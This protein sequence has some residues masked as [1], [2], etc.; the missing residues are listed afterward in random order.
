DVGQKFENLVETLESGKA[1]LVFELT[2]GKSLSGPDASTSEDMLVEEGVIEHGADYALPCGKHSDT[3]VN[4]GR[5][6]H[7]EGAL[8]RVAAALRALFADLS[9]DTIVTNG[10]AMATLARRLASLCQ[11][12]DLRPVREIMCEG[13]D[14]PIP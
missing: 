8:A 13:Y 14:P 3:F 1:E 9:F 10:W 5:L 11:R 6:C 2:P 12:P 4:I 7:S